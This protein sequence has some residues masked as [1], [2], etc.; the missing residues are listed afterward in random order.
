[1]LDFLSDFHDFLLE[2]LIFRYTIEEKIVVNV[3][4]CLNFSYEIV[5]QGHNYILDPGTT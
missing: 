2:L 4:V 1:M 5:Q 3:V